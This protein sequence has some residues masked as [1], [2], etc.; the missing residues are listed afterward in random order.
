MWKARKGTLEY[1]D[2]MKEHECSISHIESARSMEPSGVLNIYEKSVENLTLCFTSYIGD[3]DSKV[4]PTVVKGQT[5][6]P[7]K[8]LG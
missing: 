3:G 8:C 6:G 5:Y 1:E 4:Y 2:F 7:N